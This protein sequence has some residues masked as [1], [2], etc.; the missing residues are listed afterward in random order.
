MNQ[1]RHGPA[2]RAMRF[3]CTGV[4]RVLLFQRVNFVPREKSE[5]LEILNHVAIV[6]VHPELIKSIDTGAPA[7]EPDGAGLGFAE[8]GTVRLRD[9]RLDQSESGA[10]ELAPAQIDAG[11]DVT[12][13]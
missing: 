13:L 2:Q 6:G 5:I 11:R 3:A 1:V 4:F 8:L 10:T 9:E 12:P 7:V